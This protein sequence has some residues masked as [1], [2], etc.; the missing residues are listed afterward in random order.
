[1]SSLPI[2]GDIYGICIKSSTAPF[3]L[4]VRALGWST[5]LNSYM[6]ISLECHAP[7]YMCIHSHVMIRSIHSLNTDSP[8][9]M[10]VVTLTPSIAAVIITCTLRQER[11]HLILSTLNYSLIFLSSCPSTRRSVQSVR[12]LAHTMDV[13]L[14]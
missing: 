4:L 7:P 6:Y 10:G 12:L 9:H 14:R 3:L 5:L 11:V 8:L 13:V 1:M 2:K